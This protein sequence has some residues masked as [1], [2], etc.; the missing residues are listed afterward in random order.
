M[1]RK[2]IT[3]LMISAISIAFC[4][5][6]IAFPQS[7]TGAQSANGQNSVTPFP[8]VPVVMEYEHAP[9]FFLQWITKDPRYTMIEASV[10]QTSPPIYQIVLTGKTEGQRTYYS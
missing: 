8:I 2:L 7:Q 10:N 6:Q 4:F 3:A 1:R 9:L 5:S